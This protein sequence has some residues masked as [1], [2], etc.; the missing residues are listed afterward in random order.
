MRP[1][2]RSQPVRPRQA[3]V[4][5]ST[6]PDTTMSPTDRPA[7]DPLLARLDEALR[8]LVAIGIV[9]VLLLPAARG[10]HALLG[11]W[12]LWLVAMPACAWW[13]LHRF[14]VPV[15]ATAGVRRLLPARRAPRRAAQAH[16]RRRGAGL[17][18]AA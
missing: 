13:A 6:L 18:R 8:A 7:A 10:H 11:W 1:R 14:P 5:A 9:L 16:R 3:K 2:R 17:A 4:A 12:P 15:E